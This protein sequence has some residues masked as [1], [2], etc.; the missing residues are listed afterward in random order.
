MAVQLVAK[1][2]SCGEAEG[3]HVHCERC[4]CVLFDWEAGTC[5]SCARLDGGGRCVDP[6]CPVCHKG[7]AP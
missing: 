1:P 7:G 3:L 6:A 5:T 4:G 2:C